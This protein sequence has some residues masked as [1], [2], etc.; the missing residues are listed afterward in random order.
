[1][2]ANGNVDPTGSV[3][4]VS[5]SAPS[6]RSAPVLT[7][8]RRIVIVVPTFREMLAEA[9]AAVREVEPA[10][11]EQEI[12]AGRR[13]RPRRARARRVR[14]GRPPR[15]G[16]HPAG[17]PRDSVEGRIPD[18]SSHVVVY[19][20][21]GT[22]SRLRR[23]DHAGLGYTDVPRWSAGSTGGRTRA[24]TGR[25]P[26]AHARAAQPVPAPPAPARGRRDRPAEAA[27]LEGPPA[28]RRR[29]RVARRPLPGGGRRGHPRDHRHGRGRRLQP[30]AP[31]PAQ[32]RPD[33]RAQGRL[34]Q[35]DADR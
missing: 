12:A 33:R 23:P 31:D 6:D 5:R 18:K 34:G 15:C 2:P 21:G 28:R 16:A 10:E 25:P 19:C 20:A 24:V 22:R 8:R 14:A 29:P 32:H 11:A 9:K 30:P 13:R 17:H 26:V 4:P 27:R 35:E 3:L 1:M 7:P